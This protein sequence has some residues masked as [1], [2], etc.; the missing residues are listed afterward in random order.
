MLFV[1]KRHDEEK[2]KKALRMSKFK[3]ASWRNRGE[4]QTR[5]GKDRVLVF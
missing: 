2:R 3:L 1:S 4:D 5:E